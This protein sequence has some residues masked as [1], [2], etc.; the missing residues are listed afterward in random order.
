M[1]T[2]NDIILHLGGRV[3]LD[4]LVKATQACSRLIQVEQKLIAKD[5]PIEWEIADLQPGSA[6]IVIRGSASGKS[7]AKAVPNV[8]RGTIAAAAAYRRNE[9]SKLTPEERKPLDSLARLVNGSIK[10]VRFHSSTE[11]EAITRVAKEQPGDTDAEPVIASRGPQHGSVVGYVSTLS[12]QSAGLRFTLRDRRTGRGVLCHFGPA[13][14]EAAR[15]VWDGL[16]RVEGLVRRDPQTGDAIA[17]NEVSAIEPVASL[18]REDF[19][20]ARGATR[21]LVGV[22][23]SEEAVRRVRDGQ[24]D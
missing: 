14:K 20:R 4:A 12:S 17:V 9:L 11:A 7:N 23:T 2:D 13:F 24:E 1:G 3:T 21:H 16:V 6:T 10:E 18:G 5:V 15:Q 8:V 19:R 22:M